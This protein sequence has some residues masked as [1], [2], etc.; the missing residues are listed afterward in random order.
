MA[1]RFYS[2]LQ[3][4]EGNVWK[5]EIHDIDYSGASASFTLASPGFTLA[6]TG[7]QD[8]FAPLMPSTCT[9]HMM[10]QNAAELALITDLADFT[11]GRFLVRIIADPDGGEVNH[12]LGMMTAES[13]AVVDEYYPQAID[14]R[15]ICGLATLSTVPFDE[16]AGALTGSTTLGRV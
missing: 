15:A 10:A 1:V 2:E 6:Y 16:D 7:G 5:V 11:E 14:M 9:I 3:S 4:S 8:I 12:W 13:I